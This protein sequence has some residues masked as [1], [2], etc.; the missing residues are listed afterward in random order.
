MLLSAEGTD[1]PLYAPVSDQPIGLRMGLLNMQAGGKAS[2]L[3]KYK[4]GWGT[5]G[6][7]DDINVGDYYK[8]QIVPPYTS[9][10]FDVEIKAVHKYK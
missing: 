10:I 5:S 4:Y 9:V 6:I 2:M 3:I 1:E 8:Q 7:E